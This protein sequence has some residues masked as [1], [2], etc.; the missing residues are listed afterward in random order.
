MKPWQ[1]AVLILGLL[2]IFS[3][4]KPGPT[5]GPEPGPAPNPVKTLILML[6][7]SQHGNLPP[8]ALGAMEELRAAGRDVR[9]PDDD[10]VDGLGQVPP[11]LRPALEP[12]RAIM[13][14]TDGKDDALI[15]LD[16]ER[17]VKAV[18][19]PES[20]EAIIAAVKP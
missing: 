4:G 6:H 20:K 5:P 14:G 12:G 2:L 17:V 3:D 7:E 13:G 10:D 11:W 9:A 16:G 19:L 18:K 1:W 15:V 8:Y